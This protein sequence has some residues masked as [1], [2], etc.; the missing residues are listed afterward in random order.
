MFVVA[1]GIFVE[2]FST[3]VWALEHVGLV[4]LQHVGWY[5]PNQRL[6]PPPLHWKADSQPLE[7]QGNPPCIMHSSL[8]V[9]IPNFIPLPPLSRAIHE[10]GFYVCESISHWHYI[11]DSSYKWYHIFVFDFL[12]LYP[13]LVPPCWYKCHYVILFWWLSGSSVFLYRDIHISV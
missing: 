7:P 13:L 6:N 9:L 12:S 11:S 1:R 10:F 4:A 5:F 2:A 3:C 8:N